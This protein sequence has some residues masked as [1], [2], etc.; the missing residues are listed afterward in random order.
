MTSMTLLKSVLKASKLSNVLVNIIAL[1]LIGENA[2]V[3]DKTA[4]FI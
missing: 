2:N 1:G 3:V 4:I